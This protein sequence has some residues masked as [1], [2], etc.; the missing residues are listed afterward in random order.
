MAR[1]RARASVR[2]SASRVRLW[3]SQHEHP[4]S[5][6]QPLQCGPGYNYPPVPQLNQHMALHTATVIPTTPHYWALRITITTATAI[7]PKLT[8]T[9]GH[10]TNTP[11]TLNSRRRW[12][13]A[14]CIC[15]TSVSSTPMSQPSPANRPGLRN[16]SSTNPLKEKKILFI[17]PARAPTTSRRYTA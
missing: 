2:A 17:H 8:V 6:P 9:L 1:A 5:Q 3:P 11:A 12:S 14:R 15:K 4:Y 16:F 7:S 13:Y 10:T